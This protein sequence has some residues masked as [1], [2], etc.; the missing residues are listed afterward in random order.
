MILFL[1]RHGETD[2]N[3]ANRWQGHTDVALNDVGRAQAAA[4]GARL[5]GLGVA[6]VFASDLSRAR[7]TAEIVAGLLGAPFLGVDA[8][9]RERGFGVFEGLTRVECEAR[10]PEAWRLYSGDPRCPP[11]GAEP[12]DRV[13]ARMGA[14]LR[15]LAAAPDGADDPGPALVVSHGG[16]IRAL[17]SHERGAPLP[18]IPNGASFRIVIEGGRFVEIDE[19]P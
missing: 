19:L 9:L 16:A 17:L 14:A 8:D 1:A 3:R 2:W 4:L 12:H 5:R 11:P 15:R 18:P 6:R 7:E 10:H 13:V